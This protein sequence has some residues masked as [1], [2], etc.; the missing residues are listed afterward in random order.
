MR[1]RLLQLLMRLN[2]SYNHIRSDV[3]LKRP[4]LTV[5]QAYSVV[6]QEESQRRLGL[7]EVNKDPLTILVGKGQTCKN[8]KPGLIC[9]YCGYKGH[10]KENCYKIIGYPPDF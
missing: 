9:E 7:V 4:M 6:V 3:M 1:Q 8:K 10:L 2:E 5:N